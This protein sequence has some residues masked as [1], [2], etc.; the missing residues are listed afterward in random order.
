MKLSPENQGFDHEV[1][2]EEQSFVRKSSQI[3]PKPK[4]SW[5]EADAKNALERYESIVQ[6]VAR[7]LKP[8]AIPGQA[9]DHDD[10]CAEGR[11]AVLEA[12]ATYEGFGVSEQTW[13]RIRI[14]Q[15]MIDAIRRLDV[16]SRD[17]VKQVVREQQKPLSESHPEIVRDP[18]ARRLVPLDAEHIDNNRVEGA[19]ELNRAAS[20]EEQLQG[21]RLMD[22][23]KV[24]P[25]RQREAMELALM[26]G[27]SLKDIGDMMGISESRVCQLQKAAIEILRRNVVDSMRPSASLVPRS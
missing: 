16:K 15:R 5:S 23:L 22:A 27:L 12:L 19:Y 6:R 21:Q 25:P 3:K 26:K 2:T 13:V 7:K 10:L 18:A 11:I 17:E 9:L 14:R 24:L 20:P 1:T 8:S 4:M